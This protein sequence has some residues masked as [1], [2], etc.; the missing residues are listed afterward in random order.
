MGYQALLFCSDEKLSR[1]VSQVFV[2]LDFVVD[3]V[4]EPFAAVKKLMAQH[5]DAIV[6]DCAYEQ[7][8]AL[9]FKSARNSSSNQVSLAIG[10]VEGQTGVAKA[11][12]IGANLVL[13]KPINVDQAKGTLRVARGLIRKTMETAHPASQGAAATSAPAEAAT[14]P[15]VGAPSAQSANRIVDVISSPSAHSE[16][17]EFGSAHSASVTASSEGIEAQPLGGKPARDWSTLAGNSP[18]VVSIAKEQREEITITEVAAPIIAPVVG[19]SPGSAGAAAAPARTKEIGEKEVVVPAEKEAVA[20]DP[21]ESARSA[22]IARGKASLSTV[23]ETASEG[24]SFT[25]DGDRGGSS[26][27]RKVLIAAMGVLTLACAGYFGWMKFGGSPHTA[28]AQFVTITTQ[29]VANVTHRAPD[30]SA[31]ATVPASAP[32]SAV[33]EKSIPQIAAAPA[34]SQPDTNLTPRTASSSTRHSP[35]AAAPPATTRIT[36][37]PELEAQDFAPAPLVV[38]SAARPVKAQVPPDDSAAALPPPL[39]VPATGDNGLSEV[40]SSAS[41]NSAK[42]T[43]T[44]MKI[45]QGVSQGMVIRR[46][47]PKYPPSALATHTEGAVQI[48]AT[49]SKEGFVI[50]PKVLSGDRML[51]AAALAAVRQWRYKPYYLDGQPV[52]IQTQITIS[53]KAR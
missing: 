47:Q 2:E 13:T 7:N 31:P 6:V 4:S 48:E 40:L 36:I 23:T 45:S 22:A 51:A 16:S 21:E 50:D 17:A 38:R 39:S 12:R 42:P 1:V 37:R 10:L 44:R 46:V 35:A 27:S 43:L 26:G 14:V 29:F 18:P 53:F 28:I 33:I 24:P 20:E 49:I 32:S 41:S 19:T 5:Y 34:S 25:I 3:P 8:A 52:E 9:I 15:L 11:Y 30:M